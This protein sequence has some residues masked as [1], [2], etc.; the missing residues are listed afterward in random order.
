M[1][2]AAMFYVCLLAGVPFLELRAVSDVVGPRDKAQWDIPGAV[3]ALNA[4]LGRVL[5]IAV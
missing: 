1:E 3:A 2:G 5:N 4:E